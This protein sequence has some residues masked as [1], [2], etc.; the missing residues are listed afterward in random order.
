MPIYEALQERLKAQT[1]TWLIR[2]VAG[3]MGSDLLEPLLKL[4]Q[5]V[6]GLDNLVA[7]KRDNLAGMRD[8]VGA[9]RWRQFR[10]IDGY[11]RVR[12]DCR[13]T[14]RAARYVH[15]AARAVR[16]NPYSYGVIARC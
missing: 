7:G 5:Q 9:A 2:G 16:A 1:Q 11:I 8:A 10:L 3:F 15:E 6:I 14:C 12:G 4:N 13:K